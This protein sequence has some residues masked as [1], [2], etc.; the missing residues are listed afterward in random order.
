MRDAT[1]PQVRCLEAWLAGSNGRHPEPSVAP[2][3]APRALPADSDACHLVT[4]LLRHLGEDPARPGLLGTPLR[5]MRSL[6]FLT[7]GYETDVERVINGAVFE[8]AYSEMVVV[9]DIELYS[10]CE[11][12]L[13]PF[14]GRAHVA[15]IPDGRVLGLSKLGR[16]VDL[17]ARR[18]QLQERLTTQIAEAVDETLAPLGVAVVIE[19]SHL[20][21]MMRGVQKQNSRTLTSSMR[22][23]FLVDERT[24]AEFMD[25]IHGPNCDGGSQ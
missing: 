4:E 12:H 17:F 13:L 16:I 20:C 9:R 15:Y 10:L 21:L 24:R 7:T 22:G 25:L 18:L 11:H 5:V 19:A 3:D 14:F 6:H 1:L 2:A 23:M 8:V